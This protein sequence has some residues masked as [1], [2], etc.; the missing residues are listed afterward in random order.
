[1]Y[2]A[3]IWPGRSIELSEISIGETLAKSRLA[4]WLSRLTP[5]PAFTQLALTLAELYA[6][7]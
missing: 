1:M 5:P 7:R 6:E 2:V 3:Q 4:P